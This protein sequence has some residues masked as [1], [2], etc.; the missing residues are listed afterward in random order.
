[1]PRP[2]VGRMPVSRHPGEQ[3]DRH[4]AAHDRH[5]QTGL[6]EQRPDFENMP[7][8][9][10]RSPLPLR[11][12]FWGRA[13]LQASNMTMTQPHMHRAQGHR[14]HAQQRLC[15]AHVA[16]KAQVWQ[17][18]EAARTSAHQDRP[19][20][21]QLRLSRMTSPGTRCTDMDFDIAPI[22]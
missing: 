3:L 20:S 12:H 16:H 9:L 5:L 19:P 6:L 15:I 4:P 7:L 17:A 2:D 13:C 21:A 14:T 11:P 8:R 10:L 18:V 1:M 22:E